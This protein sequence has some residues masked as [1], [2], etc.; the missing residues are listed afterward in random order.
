VQLQLLESSLLASFAAACLACT[1]V[2]VAVVPAAVLQL[3]LRLLLLLLLLELSLAVQRQ[4]AAA[5]LLQHLLHLLEEVPAPLKLLQHP[6]PAAVAA[7][8]VCC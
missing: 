5:E 2:D 3:H 6:T 1:F 7:A 8:G 4:A